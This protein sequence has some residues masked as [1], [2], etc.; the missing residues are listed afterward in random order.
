MKI[1]WIGSAMIY[2]N[3]QNQFVV[4][5]LEHEQKMSVIRASTDT[6]GVKQMVSER[7]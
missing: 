5:P 1:P 4:W 6:V 3:S 7:R 2:I